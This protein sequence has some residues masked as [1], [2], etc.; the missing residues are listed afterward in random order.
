[1]GK[2]FPETGTRVYR[3]R[4]VTEKRENLSF[5]LRLLIV[6][7]GWGGNKVTGWK[8]ELGFRKRTTTTENIE[9]DKNIT[10]KGLKTKKESN[11]PPKGGK[12]KN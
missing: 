3:G 10:F 4:G 5:R 12:E 1:V 9:K 7:G 6:K 8:I 2:R 11:K